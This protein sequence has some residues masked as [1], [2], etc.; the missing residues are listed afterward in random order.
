MYESRS[1]ATSGFSPTIRASPL[2]SIG[3]TPYFPASTYHV[4]ISL[5]SRSR[6]SA[7]TSWFS[8][9]S[10][11]TWYSSQPLSSSVTSVSAEI[12]WPKPAPASANDGPGHGHTARQPSS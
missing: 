12:G 2:P 9:K 11:A 7:A 10:S 8:A 6:W 3:S 1:G 4:A 5:I